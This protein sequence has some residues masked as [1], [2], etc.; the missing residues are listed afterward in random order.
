MTTLVGARAGQVHDEH[1]AFAELAFDADAAA[2]RVDD[3]ARDE[4]AQPEPAVLAR[5]DCTLEAF[6]DVR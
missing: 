3:A 6:E 1:G 4:Q 5:R 2:E